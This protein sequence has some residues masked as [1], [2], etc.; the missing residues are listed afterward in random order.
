MRE[1]PA[2]VMLRTGRADGPEH[3]TV[4]AG[5]KRA[6]NRGKRKIKGARLER[7]TMSDVKWR[8]VLEAIANGLTRQNVFKSTG[9]TRE[10]FEAYLVTH[11]NALKQFREA[12][13]VWLRRSW[14]SEDL[15]TMFSAMCTGITVKAAAAQLGWDD[16]KLISFYA[17]VRRDRTIRE[18]YDTAR[19]LQAEAWLDDNIDISDNRGGDTYVDN[20]GKR[21]TDHA[22]IQRD[23][24]RIDTRQ[25]T[26]SAVNRKRF[27]DHKHID[28]GGEIN[29][30]H[31]AVL[32]SA[33][34]R[35][36]KV[37]PPATIDNAS[38]QV[39]NE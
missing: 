37:N 36:E 20:H 22:V 12:E 27:G 23:K 34:K 15:D 26:M 32:G 17:L 4:R 38:Q 21:K 1:K 10:T 29:I 39:V 16:K 3:H 25:W 24:L 11:I 31:A 6:G 9:I 13:M 18:W 30:N 35:L 33:R 7:G 5:V 8:K 28:H 2:H 14:P 19:E